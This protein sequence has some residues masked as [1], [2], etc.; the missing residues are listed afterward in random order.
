MFGYVGAGAGLAF[1]DVITNGPGLPD[2]RGT[3]N[4][5]AAAG[6]VGAGYDFGH[7]VAD[8]GYRGLYINKIENNATTHPY[9]IANNWVHEVRGTVRYR[10]N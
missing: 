3:N 5:F 9:S 1:N 8:L 10:F 6:M 2:T 7:V 4:S